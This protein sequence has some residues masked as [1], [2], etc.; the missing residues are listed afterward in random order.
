MP[1]TPFCMASRSTLPPPSAPTA[2]TKPRLTWAERAVVAAVIILPFF[3]YLPSLRG[4]FLWDDANDVVVGADQLSVDGLERAWTD[5]FYRQQFY[6]VT[7]TVFWIG[8]HLWGPNPQGYRLLVLALHIVSALLLI[9]VLR[10]LEVRGAAA[11]ALLF[12]LHPLNVG[13]VAWISKL[14]NTLSAALMLAS[15][16]VFVGLL[17]LSPG[18]PLP[19]F[20]GRGWRNYGI[21]LGLFV[22][23]LLSKTAVSPLPVALALIVFWKRG[24]IE[25]ELLLLLVPMVG[26]AA[27]LGII[28]S[29]VEIALYPIAGSA[30]AWGGADSVL[31][32]GRAIAFYIGKLLWPAGLSFAYARWEPSFSDPAQLCGVVLAVGL[33]L[34]LWAMRRRLGRGP[35]VALLAGYALLFPALGFFKVWLMRFSFVADHW[36]YWAELA[37]IPLAVAG[38]A[39]LLDLLP[40]TLRRP[41]AGLAALAAAGACFVLTFRRAP[42]FTSEE[43]VWHDAFIKAPDS[44]LAEVNCGWQWIQ[45]GKLDEAFTLYEGALKVHPNESQLLLNLGYL[46][47]RRGNYEDAVAFSNRVLLEPDA[48][49][50]VRAKAERL[51]ALA[52]ALRDATPE[53]RQRLIDHANEVVEL[54]K[55]G[56]GI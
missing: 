53:E 17:P 52:T 12:A 54:K 47:M 46:D 39:H 28:T 34:V 23:A 37:W 42:I 32:A 27:G 2:A 40:A 41:S 5:I 33:P 4:G 25:T 48:S 15:A 22:L 26:L 21:A 36:V 50:R 35:I 30:Y 56:H 8:A 29:R 14:T 49:G 55:R 16:W 9:A 10:R 20:D 13:T 3:A 7:H 1:G 6:P 19:R 31:L 38:V 44:L 43:L 45:Q 24:R 51:T 11:A 18:A